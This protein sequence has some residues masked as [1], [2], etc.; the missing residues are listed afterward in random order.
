MGH[1]VIVCLAL[2][3]SF[4]PIRG[5]R[6]SQLFE[7]VHNSV[8]FLVPSFRFASFTVLRIPSPGFLVL[9]FRAGSGF[10]ANILPFVIVYPSSFPNVLD[11]MKP[12]LLPARLFARHQ[13]SPFISCYSSVPFPRPIVEQM[14]P[15]K[16]C[17][18]PK[19]RSA[20]TVGVCRS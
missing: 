6:R 2:C 3:H 18:R 15:I 8:P 19:T 12:Y 13:P 14:G 20:A 17:S 7:L 11:I 4:N 16:M 10:S 9:V 5:L 1:V